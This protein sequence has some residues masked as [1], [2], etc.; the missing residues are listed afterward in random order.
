[1]KPGWT[2]LDGVSVDR[3]WM[4]PLAG[5]GLAFSLIA[6]LAACRTSRKSAHNVV[7][8]SGWYTRGGEG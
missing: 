1:M 3:L 2:Q 6:A 5:P 8:L 4:R 7:G